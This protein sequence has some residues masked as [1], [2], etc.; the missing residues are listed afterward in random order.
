MLFSCDV[1]ALAEGGLGEMDMLE[2][3]TSGRF[4]SLARR[5]IDRLVGWFLVRLDS[6]GEA[7]NAM[8]SRR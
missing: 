6:T 4:G 2:S 8:L 3:H 5:K 7:Q 1:S